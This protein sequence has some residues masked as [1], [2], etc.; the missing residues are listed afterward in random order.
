[1]IQNRP[2]KVFFILVA[3]ASCLPALGSELAVE[4]LPLETG[5]E[6]VVH[7]SS[8]RYNDTC[9]DGPLPFVSLQGVSGDALEIF[10][11]DEDYVE[12]HA[13]PLDIQV[14]I[15]EQSHP[16][17]PPFNSM[18]V[19]V[20]RFL[21]RLTAHQALSYLSPLP[22]QSSGTHLSERSL[23][24]AAHHTHR[25]NYSFKRTAATGSGT[26]LQRSAAAA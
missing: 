5:S 12:C 7:L 24:Q 8:T 2:F 21:A 13:T 19:L 23:L 18:V 14:P 15:E 16:V 10:V 1:L 3:L 4:P 9:W 17:S 25:A 11:S 22:K 26:I 20:T 6:L